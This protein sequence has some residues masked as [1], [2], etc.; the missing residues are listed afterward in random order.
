MKA[1]LLACALLFVG[2]C[3]M[4]PNT[5]A[6]YAENGEW[7]FKSRQIRFTIPLDSHFNPSS[8]WSPCSEE[9]LRLARNKGKGATIDKCG[10]RQNTE[11]AF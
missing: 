7:S 11:N 9:S 2:G 1:F 3:A 5:L 6:E 8:G 4:T 10:E